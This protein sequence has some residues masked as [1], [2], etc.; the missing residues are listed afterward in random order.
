LN[1]QKKTHVSIPRPARSTPCSPGPG[2]DGKEASP[3]KLATH[4][5]SYCLQNYL[6]ESFTSFQDD[7][8]AM[9]GRKKEIGPR[10]FAVFLLAG[11]RAMT[12]PPLPAATGPKS[13][14]RTSGIRRVGHSKTADRRGEDFFTFVARHSFGDGHKRARPWI[15]MSEFFFIASKAGSDQSI[16]QSCPFSASAWP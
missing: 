3:T 9:S 13:F 4:K 6:C 12:T 1:A 2:F 14:F 15:G 16:F 5:D 7:Q 11:L 10:S 8:D